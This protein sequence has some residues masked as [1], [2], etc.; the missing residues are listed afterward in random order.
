MQ[1]SNWRKLKVIVPKRRVMIGTVSSTQVFTVAV[2]QL[3]GETP[4]KIAKFL[5]KRASQK[6]SSDIHHRQTARFV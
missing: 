3:D 6:N 5:E 2:Y 1:F 4:E